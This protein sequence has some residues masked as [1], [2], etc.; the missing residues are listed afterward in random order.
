MIDTNDMLPGDIWREELEKMIRAADTVIWLVS[1]I[2]MGSDEVK[3]ELEILRSFNKRIIPG[4]IDDID[5]DDLPPNINRLHVLSLLPS[6][7]FET[8]LDELAD[9][10]KVPKAWIQTHTWLGDQARRK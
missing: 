5:L 9:T 1:K 4:L 2:S 8:Q 10:L 3:W 6:D 7:D